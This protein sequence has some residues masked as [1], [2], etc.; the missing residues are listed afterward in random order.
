MSQST[1]QLF[2]FWRPVSESLTVPLSPSV[3]GLPQQDLYKTGL[4]EPRRV[5]L[6][7]LSL[8][9]YENNR[10]CRLLFCSDDSCFLSC[11]VPHYWCFSE[12][13]DIGQW[14]HKSTVE[15]KDSYTS[16]H[17]WSWWQQVTCAA[18][19]WEYSACSYA[20]NAWCTPLFCVFITYCLLRV[21]C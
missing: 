3:H 5:F 14:A 10:T 12:I 20:Q 13:N 21:Y 4:K 19:A 18:A 11:R 8:L 1:T 17:S 6:S 9:A 16:N 7:L 15:L 2:Q